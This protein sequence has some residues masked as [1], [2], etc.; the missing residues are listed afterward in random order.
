MFHLDMRFQSTAMQI[1]YSDVKHIGIWG[2]GK[3]S[4]YHSFLWRALKFHEADK[5]LSEIVIIFKDQTN[6]EP[7]SCALVPSL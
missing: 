4:T 6:C 2:R 5:N 1:A 7:K 3:V